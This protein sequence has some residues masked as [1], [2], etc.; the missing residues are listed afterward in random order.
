MQ[1]A[2]I[3]RSCSHEKV[4][5]AAVASIGFDFRKTIEEAAAR[6]GTSTGGLAVACV[7]DFASSADERDWQ[8]LERKLKHADMPV[9]DGLRHILETTLADDTPMSGGD[10]GQVA[11]LRQM[12][13]D[14]GEWCRCH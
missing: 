1:F 14:A 11:H 3:F 10:A 7:R 13:G 9:L 2:E 8:A 6:R 12:S 4:A 5:E